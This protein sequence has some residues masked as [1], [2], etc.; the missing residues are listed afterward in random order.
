M[1][2]ETVARRIPPGPLALIAEANSDSREMYAES[3]SLLGF[4]IEQARDGE[5]ALERTFS[6][7]PDVVSTELTLPK[8]DGIDFCQRIRNRVDTRDIPI[9]I[10]TATVDAEVVRRALD[11]GCD[12]ILIKPC[13]P[14]TLARELYRLHASGLQA[15]LAAAARRMLE[16]NSGPST[17]GQERTPQFQGNSGS[18]D[19]RL[20][21]GFRRGR[22]DLPAASAH[23]PSC[24][25]DTAQMT[26][27]LGTL[28]VCSTCGRVVA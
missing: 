26:A 19:R 18:A 7:H 3:L 13:L 12:S 6:V 4:R 22:R 25:G 24:G 8:I 14:D 17:S 1:Q 11:A 10:V 5:E 23:C 15:R 20:P 9:V 27:G 16:A 21:A 2:T 28:T